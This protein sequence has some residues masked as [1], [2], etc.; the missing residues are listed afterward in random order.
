MTNKEKIEKFIKD[1]NLN[2]DGALGSEL[3]SM[4]VV[5]AGYSLYLKCSLEDMVEIT[6][7]I[8]P[9]ATG[10]LQGSQWEEF[11]R[12]FKYAEQYSYGT[13][14]YT[15]EAKSEYIFEPCENS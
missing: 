15:Y 1:N 14:W 7:E 12:V 10:I 11:E 2:F 6:N 5:L 9:E 3:N 4:C 8:Y 13:W